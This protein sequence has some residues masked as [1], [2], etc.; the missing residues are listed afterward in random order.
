MRHLGDTPVIIGVMLVVALLLRAV[1]GR[2]REGLFVIAAVSGQAVVFISTTALVERE[3]PEVEQ[4]D[5]S[6]PTSSFPSWCT[7]APRSPCTWRSLSPR[8]AP[9]A[10]DGRAT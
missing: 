4:L 7:R 2:W 3:R 6:P 5:S 1:L 8:S 10:R 9:Y